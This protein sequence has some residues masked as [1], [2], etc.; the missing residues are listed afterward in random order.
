VQKIEVTAFD[1]LDVSDEPLAFATG[2]TG[3]IFMVTNLMDLAGLALV[4]PTT[5]SIGEWSC[6]IRQRQDYPEWYFFPASNLPLWS[7]S[8]KFD[9]T[10]DFSE[11]FRTGTAGVPLRLKFCHLVVDPLSIGRHTVQFRFEVPSKNIVVDGPELKFQVKKVF[12]DNTDC[13]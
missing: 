5:V 9:K 8:S 4:E 11:R 10:K 7:V 3:E 13:W 6:D 12:K 2:Q 1:G